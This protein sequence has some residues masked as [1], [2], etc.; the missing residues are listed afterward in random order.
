M[1][2]TLQGRPLWAPWIPACP[3][4]TAPAGGNNRPL[5]P[6]SESTP[7]SL[8]L[9]DGEGPGVRPTAAPVLLRAARHPDPGDGQQ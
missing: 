1:A 8:S 9:R 2:P 7:P 4:V 3:E 6:A 5:P